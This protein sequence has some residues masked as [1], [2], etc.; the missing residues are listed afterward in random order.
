M[1][2]SRCALPI[3]L[4][5]SL[6]VPAGAAPPVP[7]GREIRVNADTTNS[8]DDPSVVVFPDGGFVVAWSSTTARYRLFDSHGRPVSGERRL[9]VG[10]QLDQIAADRS[11]FLAAWTDF[12]SPRR[13]FVRRFNRD[14]A[15]QGASVPVSE[16]SD[17]DRHD[18]V[19]A[20]AP[21][22]GFVVA[23][24]ADVPV[25]GSDDGNVF[26]N[27]VA[28]IFTPQRTPV[29]PE[30]TLLQGEQATAAGDDE[31]NAFPTSLVLAPDGTLSAIVHDY[32]GAACVF[33]FLMRVPP[34]GPR[35][36][37]NLAQCANSDAVYSSL[38]MGRDGSLVA[39][40]T[41]FDLLAQR[42]AP[43]GTPRGEPFRVNKTQGNF[44]SDPGVALQAGGS[45][46]IVWAEDERDG[47]ERGIF[48]RAFAANGMPRTPDFRINTTTAGDQHEPAIAAA[49]Q[50]PVVV[51]WTQRRSG[52]S[53][54][55]VFARVLAAQP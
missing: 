17:N 37:E 53:R 26:T 29:T 42:F 18:A 46:V 54:S 36:S 55:D 43:D 21:N 28:R 20:A 41:S 50:G 22:G 7:Q 27:A 9:L 52:E 44:Q 15:P 14:G 35:E 23:W 40:W 24:E 4:L 47:D 16:P 11:G 6:S 12:G 25:P 38:A 8:H 32:D 33:T 10:G 39:T 19:L 1:T 34:S 5:A 13:V 2:K 3:L 48:G 49:R 45:F 30:L 51:V 31:I